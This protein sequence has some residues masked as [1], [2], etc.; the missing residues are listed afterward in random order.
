MVRLL[1]RPFDGP[2]PVAWFDFGDREAPPDFNPHLTLG[3]RLKEGPAGG[4]LT[5]VG[6]FD[7]VEIL[8]SHV[9]HG[10]FGLHFA[11][12]LGLRLRHN[13]TATWP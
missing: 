2:E 12:L 8:Y 13:H 10:V 7:L 3:L 4:Y 11:P 9:E 6:L 1:L 5:R